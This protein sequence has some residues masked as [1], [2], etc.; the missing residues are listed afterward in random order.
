[1]KK[2]DQFA[3][4]EEFVNDR[5]NALAVIALCNPSNA[6]KSPDDIAEDIFQQLDS[7]NLTKEE[8]EKA[9]NR[10]DEIKVGIID[11]LYAS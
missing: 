10:F 4:E 6:H 2:Y 3:T 5:A 1:M 9:Q 7:G 8:T 11:R